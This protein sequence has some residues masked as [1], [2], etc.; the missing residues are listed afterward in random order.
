MNNV[1]IIGGA[2]FIGSHLVDRCLTDDYIVTILDNFSTGKRKFLQKSE[3][4]RI[5]EGDILN[6]ED[7]EMVFSESSPEIVFHLAAIHHIPTCEKFPSLTLNTNVVGLQ[8]L[9]NICYR[10]KKIRRIV[11]TS[12]GAIYDDV[13]KEALKESNALKAC[14]IYG[15]SKFAGEQ[16]LNHF[17]QKID[18]EVVIARLFN[19]VGR[20]ETNNHIIPDI[21][22]QI[23]QGNRHLRLG[24]LFPKRD[25][26]HVEDVADAL[27]RLGMVSIKDQFDI[28]NVG[29]GVE[30]SVSDLVEKLSNIIGEKIEIE[31]VP[32]YQRKLDRPSQLAD[33][34][35]IS[36]LVGWVPKKSLSQALMEIWEELIQGEE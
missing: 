34:S 4:L 15:I 36:N 24:N 14:G 8:N 35:K 29:A 23:G 20:R 9:L 6:L 33:I 13:T 11:F 27:F 32:E 18:K 10:N 12:T 31:S 21:M 30:Y 28:F 22:A 16:L 26:I 3:K 5:F 19:T 7:L 17:T 25:Y 1:L 2:G